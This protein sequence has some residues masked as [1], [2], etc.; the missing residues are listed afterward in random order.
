MYVHLYIYLFYFIITVALSIMSRNTSQH[1]L[2]LEKDLDTIEGYD[3]Y[4]TFPLKE[5][6]IKSGYSSLV[7]EISTNRIVILDGYIGVDWDEVSNA[8]S[9]KL[10]KEGLSVDLINIVDY[11]KQEKEIIEMVQPYLGDYDSIFGQRADLLL[12]DYFDL[13]KLENLQINADVDITLVYGTG[14]SQCNIEGFLIYF[15]LPKNELQYRMRSHNIS[16]LGHSCYKPPKEAY[17]HF[18]FV[19]WVVLNKEKK[20]LLPDIQIIVDQQRPNQPTWTSGSALRATLNAMSQSYFRVRPWFEPGVW[21]G[22][23]MKNRFEGLPE[24]VPNYAWSFEMIVPENGILLESNGYILEI[25][26]DMLQNSDKV[27]H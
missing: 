20:R 19:D 7:N 4:P 26:F 16:N 14:A 15:D 23:W 6:H 13:E 21:G 22:Q 3:I 24:N 18:Y 12:G 10:R 1:L 9:N 2:P 11:L 8:I 5:G 27:Y 25:S 17:K